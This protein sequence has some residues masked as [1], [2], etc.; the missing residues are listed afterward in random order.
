[1][2]D[3]PAN[4]SRHCSIYRC[5]DRKSV[6]SWRFVRGIYFQDGWR[7]SSDIFSRKSQGIKIFSFYAVTSFYILN[8]LFLWLL[9]S[10]FWKYQP[11]SLKTY[12]WKKILFICTLYRITQL[13]EMLSTTILHHWNTVGNPLQNEASSGNRKKSEEKAY[14]A[15]LKQK[16]TD[17]FTHAKMAA[18]YGWW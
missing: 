1:M 16:Q 7:T 17:C 8:T 18:D 9:V 4:V 12:R 15:S 13:C 3:L 6:H 2:S 14:I 11:C 10:H 5:T